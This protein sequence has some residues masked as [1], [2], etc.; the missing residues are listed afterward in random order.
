[1]QKKSLALIL[2]C[3]TLALS[4]CSLFESKNKT[5]IDLGAVGPRTKD[6]LKTV[7]NGILPDEENSLH[8]S[9]ELRGDENPN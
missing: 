1:M 5:P 8:T 9:Q 7:P 6:Q 3:C 2:A 4:G